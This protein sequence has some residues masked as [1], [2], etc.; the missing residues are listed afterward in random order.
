MGIRMPYNPPVALEQNQPETG[1]FNI[2]LFAGSLF[3]C[4]RLAA[5][6]MLIS[7]QVKNISGFWVCEVFRFLGCLAV[8]TPDIC[9]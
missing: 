5:F 6:A 8:N 4:L 9:G 2:S 3:T 1:F 7:P